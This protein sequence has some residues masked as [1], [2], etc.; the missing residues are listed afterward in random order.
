MSGLGDTS[1]HVVFDCEFYGIKEGVKKTIPKYPMTTDST[2]SLTCETTP[3]PAVVLLHAILDI[4]D[5]LS[6]EVKVIHQMLADEKQKAKDL[7][8]MPGCR[9]CVNELI[10]A[11]QLK[12]PE[13]VWTSESFAKEIGCSGAAVRKTKT[14][15]E[16][17]ERLANEKQERPR[18]KGYKDKRGNLEAFDADEKEDFGSET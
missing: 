8:H 16:Y 5:P 17:Q 10:L 2:C 1:S 18:R 14:W 6:D 12:H 7:P 15:R 4:L 9:L 3:C 13:R 11:L